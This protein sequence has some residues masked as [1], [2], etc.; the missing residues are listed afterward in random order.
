MSK[1]RQKAR[2]ARQAARRAEVEA[3]AAQRAKRVRKQV[4]LQR[5]KPTVPKRRR[6]YGALPTRV[7]YQVVV[8]FLAVQVVGWY[9]LSG[10]GVRFSLAV[11]TAAVLLVLINTRRRSTR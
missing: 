10:P 2:V 5:V 11:L 7:W 3:A 4:L 9:F 8:I 1:E 6:R